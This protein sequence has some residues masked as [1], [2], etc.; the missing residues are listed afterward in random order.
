MF[1]LILL[2]GA[3]FSFFTQMMLLKHTSKYLF[4]SKTNGFPPLTEQSN[5]LTYVCCTKLISC[6]NRSMQC[7]GAI[8][9]STLGML[10]N[11]WNLCKHPLSPD[12]LDFLCPQLADCVPV[13]WYNLDQN[14]LCSVLSLS[15]FSLCSVRHFLKFRTCFY[16][17]GLL[18]TGTTLMR[19]FLSRA[20]LKKDDGLDF[21]SA[22][23]GPGHP[24]AHMGRWKRC[25]M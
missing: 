20:G 18:L 17:Q 8:W 16:N 11:G 5:T 4:N 10:C 9:K 2:K 23:S 15:Q 7:M 12:T 24:V 3:A 19:E 14:Q 1:K 6:S 25:C 13:F 21:L 22:Y